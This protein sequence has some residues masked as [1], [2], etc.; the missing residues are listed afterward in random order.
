MSG[1]EA[2]FGANNIDK[3]HRNYRILENAK[4]K[5]SEVRIQNMSHLNLF[6]KNFH[7]ICLSY[8]INMNL[9]TFA[10]NFSV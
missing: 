5:T 8:L 3:L 9:F 6:L 1:A 7:L 4:E 2:Q 10:L